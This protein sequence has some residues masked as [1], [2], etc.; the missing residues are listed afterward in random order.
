MHRYQVGIIGCGVISRTYAGDIGRFFP[1]L[2]I[3]AC[4]DLDLMSAEKL[5][6]EFG[7]PKACSTEELL[8]DPEIELVIN[9]TKPQAHTELNRKILEAGKHLFCEKPFSQTP[10]EAQELLELADRKGLQAGSAP[11]TFLASGLQSVRYYLDAGLIGKPFFITA[12]MTTFGVETWHP[13]PRSFYARGSG[14][15]YDMAP[16]YLTALI[17]LAGPIERIAAFTAR[18]SETRRVYVGALAG[19]EIPSEVD[20]HYSAILRMRN[21][22]VVNL[23]VSY[24]IYRSSL[25]M[26]E[27]YGDGGTLAYPDPNF[28]G[29]APKVYRKE[30]FT[31]PIYRDTE[32]AR[33]RKETFYELPELFPRPKDYSRG[34]GVADLA[35]AIETGGV[36]R[37]RGMIVHTIEAINGLMKAAETGEVYRMKTTCE[38]PDPLKPGAALGEL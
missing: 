37:T 26:F 38:R 34:I 5:A 8:G 32:E 33:Q 30:Q 3:T 15:Q 2:Q 18:P 6:G 17:S 27:I 9:L 35:R 7:I 25:P 11:D 31:D 19:S 10:E 1:Q 23:N 14:P 21:G 29:G 22:V 24:D 13:S 4:A 20:T 12:N 36:N 16:Y 28:G